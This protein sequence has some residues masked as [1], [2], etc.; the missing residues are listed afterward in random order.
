[1]G[2]RSRSVLV[3]PRQRA[4]RTRREPAKGKG[5]IL[6]QTVGGKHDGGIELRSR[7]NETTTDSGTGETSSA[8][9]IHFPES[10]HRPVVALPSLR[11]HSA[12]RR[13]RNRRTDRGGLR[14]RL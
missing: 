8:D 10:P 13:S 4:N 2:S 1:M 5:D 7:V 6:A 3:V 11:A 9:G 14:G 12:R